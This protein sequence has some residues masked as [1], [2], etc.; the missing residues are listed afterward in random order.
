MN[1]SVDTALVR[2]RGILGEKEQHSGLQWTWACVPYYVMTHVTTL[3]AIPGCAF[4]HSGNTTQLQPPVVPV[5]YGRKGGYLGDNKQML[6][7]INRAQL[8]K[9][10]NW[11]LCYITPGNTVPQH[12]D[13]LSLSHA[14]W[15]YRTGLAAP[16]HYLNHCWFMMCR[17]Q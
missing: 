12:L 7:Q 10:T 3:G 2:A 1:V 14:I 15:W 8:A 5:L 17:V 6:P 13:L 4:I 11:G 16:S 9:A